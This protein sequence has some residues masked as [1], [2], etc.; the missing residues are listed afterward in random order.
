M[1]IPF[2]LIAP[3]TA[4]GMRR[5]TRICKGDHVNFELQYIPSSTYC[6]ASNISVVSSSKVKKQQQHVEGMLAAGAQLEQGVVENVIADYGFI[7]PVNSADHIYFKVADVVHDDHS[8]PV[9]V[10]KVP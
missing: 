9:E 10:K 8:E 6:I 1:S 7:S 5:S 4:S 2:K 3:P